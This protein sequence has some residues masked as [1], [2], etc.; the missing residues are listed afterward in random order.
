MYISYHSQGQNCVKLFQNNGNEWIIP[1]E[2]S[3]PWIEQIA[4]ELILR[5]M[6]AEKC[7]VYTVTITSKDPPCAV[8]YT[9]NVTMKGLYLLFPSRTI[10]IIL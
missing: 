4:G 9:F 7:G 5:N 10:T 6:S 3:L 1:V 2:S 8:C